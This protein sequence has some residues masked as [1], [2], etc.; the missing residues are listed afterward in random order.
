M[1]DLPFD[2]F[3]AA[4]VGVTTLWAGWSPALILLCAPNGVLLRWRSPRSRA[5]K[6]GAGV[7]V[8]VM[9]VDAGLIALNLSDDIDVVTGTML[10]GWVAL[11]AI[12]SWIVHLPL[13]LVALG[14]GVLAIEL[15]GQDALPG[16]DPSRQL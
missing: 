15:L 5:G 8:L 10:R 9:L 7:V 3:L 1:W 14:L 16:A 13:G 11:A 12:L 4:L 2:L 6:L